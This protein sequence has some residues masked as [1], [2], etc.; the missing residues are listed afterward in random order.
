MRS[1]LLILIILL[2]TASCLPKDAVQ[3][4]DV[5]NFS[6]AMGKSQALSGDAVFYNPNSSRMKLREV[7][8]DV[9]LDGNKSAFVDQNTKVVAKAKSEFTIPVTLQL[10]EGVRLQDL[11]MGALR[12]K[13]Y[14][15]RYVGY[16]KVNI[17]G[18]PVRIPIDHS[19]E[20]KLSL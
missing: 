3:L 14:Q 11:L 20:L 17:N 6:L 9:F 10:S 4:R 8:I 15:V 2:T 1:K 5:T 13:R 12:G 18:F 7:R 16:M 19:E